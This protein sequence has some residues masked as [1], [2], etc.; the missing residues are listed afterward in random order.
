MKLKAT[1]N[2]MLTMCPQ[3]WYIFIRTIQLSAVLLLLAVFLLIAHQSSGKYEL[4]RTAWA[5]YEIPQALI[6]IAGIGAACID[7]MSAH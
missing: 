6:L 3:A 5:L 1:V 7:D 2:R 4:Y